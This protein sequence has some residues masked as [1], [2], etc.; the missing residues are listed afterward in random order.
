ML[1]YENIGIELHNVL[2]QYRVTRQMDLRSV[3]GMCLVLAH[4]I[5]NMREE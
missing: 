2:K 5:A 3:G 4:D 1:D